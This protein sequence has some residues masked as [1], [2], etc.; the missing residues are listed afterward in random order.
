MGLGEKAFTYQILPFAL[1]IVACAVAQLLYDR[2]GRRPILIFGCVGQVV[3][4]FLVAGLG[5]KTNKTTTDVNGVIASIVIFYVM[6]KISLSNLAY[7]IGSEIGGIR[8]R[9]KVNISLSMKSSCL[10]VM[11][12]A[13]FWDVIAAFVVTYSVPYLLRAPL[14]L[15]ANV[16]WI[17]GGISS[18]ALLFSV[19]F[20]PEL[21]GRS[22]EETDELFAMKLWAWQFNKA[23]TH[24]VGS[25]IARLEQRG[26]TDDSEDINM[27][28]QLK[29]II[30]TESILMIADISGAR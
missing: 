23:E 14:F 1:S 3:F 21:K 26:D 9:K 10:Q 4:M 12:F 17:F 22:L 2:I 18:A 11:A 19:F 16:G 20:V 29:V 30:H 5:T 6:T 8:M 28:D 27:D 25:R 7:V 24:G 13:T 15:G